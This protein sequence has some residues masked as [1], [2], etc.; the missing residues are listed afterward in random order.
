MTRRFWNTAI[1]VGGIVAVAATESSLRLLLHLPAGVEI[2]IKV[3]VLMTVATVVVA[4]VLRRAA[5]ESA[6]ELGELEQR[7]EEIKA[8]R[9][10]SVTDSQFVRNQVERVGVQEAITLARAQKRSSLLFPLGVALMLLSIAGPISSFLLYRS[11][12]PAA[13]FVELI[14]NMKQ[15]E[16]TVE[17]SGSDIA[18]AAARDWR[19]LVSGISFGFLFLAAAAA[20]LRLE[21]N[22][23]DTFFR[24]NHRVTFYR[25]IDAA[26]EIAEHLEDEQA[27]AEATHDLI[28]KVMAILI[29]PP[30]E[31]LSATSKPNA[32]DSAT[33]ALES[34]AKAAIDKLPGID[35]TKL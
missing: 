29:T 2:S 19:V 21:S 30:D 22:Q 1:P 12:S 16:I 33:D 32:S 5:S 14:D 13:D 6:Q 9:E 17:W 4:F 25:S 24:L 31:V 27:S 10:E 11:M 28:T 34:V 18:S 7:L 35:K 15:R 8:R 3:V 26:L 20:V 23:R